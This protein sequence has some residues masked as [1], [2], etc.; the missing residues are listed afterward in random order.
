VKY[1]WIDAQRAE[2]PLPDMCE[3]LAVSVSG[4]RAW[5]CGGTPDSTRLG[6]AQA[7]AL[8]KAIHAEVRGA[9]GSRRM[10]R[11]LQ[12]RG[13]R[14]GLARVERLMREHGIRARHKRRYKATTDSK[15]SMPVADNLLQRN[16]T[17]EAPNRVWTGDITYIATDEGWLYL[18]VVLDLFNREVVGWSIKPRMTA[19]IVTDALTMAWFRRKPDVG[20]IFHSDRGSQY[21]SHA[22][23]DKLAEYDM[24]ASMSRKANCWD[25]APTESFFNSLK[26]ER[27]HGARYATRAD[28]EADLFQYIEVF[29]N[30]RRRHSSL[31]YCSPTQ[32]LTGWL[33]KHDDQQPRAA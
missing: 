25:N 11:E 18:A 26:N 8:M 27:V 31:G 28:A 15:H 20:V 17:P 19:D 4:Y 2:Y 16:F 24:T 13:H 14:I 7:V 5:R 29:Y 23:R 22:M 9:Y 12:G 1:A 30:R 3:V 6:D 32:F 10:H 33:S 21:A